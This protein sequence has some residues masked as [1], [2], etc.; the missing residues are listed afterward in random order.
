MKSEFFKL[1]FKLADQDVDIG[2]ITDVFG[3]LFNDDEDENQEKGSEEEGGFRPLPD[4]TIEVD[5]TSKVHKCEEG[6]TEIFGWM[7]C[8][9]CGSNLRKI[10]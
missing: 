7:I 2:N 6:M 1:P 5:L 10:K 4:D 8:K 9:H 3:S